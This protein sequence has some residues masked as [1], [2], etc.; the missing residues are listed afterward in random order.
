MMHDVYILHC[1]DRKYYVVYTK[2]FKDRMARQM[3]G[4][5]KY[6]SI[7][8]PVAV[9]TVIAMPDNYKAMKLEDYL[10]TGSGRAFTLKPF[11]W[12]EKAKL[13]S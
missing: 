9:V 3:R 11:P 7:R 13:R 12:N 1:S 10:K 5:V 2:D 8:L 4:E 6:T